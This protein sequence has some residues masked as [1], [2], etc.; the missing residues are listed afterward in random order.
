MKKKNSEMQLQYFYDLWTLKESYIKFLGKG[1]TIPLDSFSI[2]KDKGKI[3]LKRPLSG[4]QTSFNQYDLDNNYK[5]S[6]CAENNYFPKQIKLITSNSVY[7]MV[8]QEINVVK[9]L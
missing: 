5:L 1:L 6:L 9:S 3:E 7:Q 2:V 4:H 8:V